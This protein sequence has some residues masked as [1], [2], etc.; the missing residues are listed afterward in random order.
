MF[1]L[2]Y[3]SNWGLTQVY[4]GDG[5]GKTTAALGLAMRSIGCGK[6]VAIIF[7]DK[8]GD[9]YNERKI[10]DRIGVDYFSYGRDRR[11]SSTEFDFSVL[12]EDRKM[13]QES[14]AKL[15]DIQGDY[16]L[17]IL[18]EVLNVIR[19]NMMKTLEL[20]DYL[21]NEKPQDLEVVI[22]G[23]GLPDDIAQRADLITEMK[24]EKHYFEQEIPPRN[25][26]EY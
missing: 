14:M 1:Y 25:G 13:A 18:D 5:K 6:K 19:L 22:T 12:E 26:I 7:F 20:S 24:M 17:I 4:Y 10:L 8:G 15:R 9:N 23:R 21:D 11:I 2:G 3:M 16:D